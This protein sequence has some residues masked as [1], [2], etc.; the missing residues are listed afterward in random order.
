MEHNGYFFDKSNWSFNTE[1]RGTEIHWTLVFLGMPVIGL[2]FLMFLPF[3]GFYLSI[4]ALIQKVGVLLRP[5]FVYTP[6]IAGQA[7]LTGH[8]TE[9]SI[10][11]NDKSPALEELEK[12]IKSLRK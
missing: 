8:S 10:S 9:G 7:H 4:Q 1:G 5:I 2:L 11:K 3:I 6:A 12:E